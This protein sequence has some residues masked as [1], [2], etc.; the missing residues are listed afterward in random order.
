MLSY[1]G[2]SLFLFAATS[3]IPTHGNSKSAAIPVPYAQKSVSGIESDLQYLF[4]NT[5]NKYGLHC[6]VCDP[7]SI[8][9]L[10][11]E[12]ENLI[13]E[14]SLTANYN[15][16]SGRVFFDV[17]TIGQQSAQYV[18]KIESLQKELEDELKKKFLGLKIFTAKPQ[19]K[20]TIQIGVYKQKSGNSW[21][22]PENI[23]DYNKAL[24]II[25][26][27]ML[28]YG[29]RRYMLPPITPYY[30]IYYTGR[31][32]GPRP[33]DRELIVAVHIAD[34]PLVVIDIKSHSAEYFELQS[35]ISHDMEM[36]LQSVFGKKRAKIR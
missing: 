2:L 36:Q 15:T 27:L 9:R 6:I 17:R 20:K 22:V 11:A 25:D 29:L 33:Y 21:R 5:A 32:F 12:S 35:T 26:K 24:S 3:Y 14:F 7:I 19:K 1:A 8:G 28:K 16:Q 18:K 31:I 34:W 4:D 23:E 13:R 10:Y 30:T